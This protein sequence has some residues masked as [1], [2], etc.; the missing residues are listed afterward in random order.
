[1]PPC[2]PL[3][4]EAIYA[5]PKTTESL[6]WNVW[7]VNKCAKQTSLF[8]GL[9]E[10]TFKTKTNTRIKKKKENTLKSKGILMTNRNYLQESSY[11][12]FL[13]IHVIVSFSSL[14]SCGF[15]VNYNFFNDKSHAF[16]TVYF[17]SVLPN[18][19]VVNFMYAV[20]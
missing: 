13:T 17:L 15:T 18:C 5:K 19:I 7:C 9:R 16:K 8:W 3:L 11:V 1:M 6:A 20:N 14:D 12:P 4:G 2:D 10:N